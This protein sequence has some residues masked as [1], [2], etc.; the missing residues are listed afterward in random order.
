MIVLR[1]FVDS[2][3]IFS[4]ARGSSY[5]VG[6]GQLTNGNYGEYELPGFP[7]DWNPFVE[8]PARSVGPPPPYK[9]PPRK[10]PPPVEL[11]SVPTPAPADRGL[12]PGNADAK[13]L[14]AKLKFV[15]C[16]GCCLREVIG[17]GPFMPFIDW[18]G[19]AVNWPRL[20]C[21]GTDRY[22]IGKAEGV[23][24]IGNMDDFVEEICKQLG[25]PEMLCRPAPLPGGQ[26]EWIPG[27]V[28]DFID[29]LNKGIN[30]CNKLTCFVECGLQL[31]EGLDQAHIPD[32][33]QICGHE[34]DYSDCQDCCLQQ[35]IAANLKQLCIDQCGEHY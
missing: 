6:E 13:E 17:G 25:L 32:L 9:K 2:S 8:G 1:Q 33:W 34:S 11:P 22:E 18:I 28:K 23:P 16:M 35:P 15:V 5:S 12:L 10:N 7:R 26:E 31:K 27:P 30:A 24:S 20:K 14:V 21:T 29:K 4:D 19:D 3:A